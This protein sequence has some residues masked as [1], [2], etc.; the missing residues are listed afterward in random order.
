M[1]TAAEMAEA[2]A[3]AVTAVAMAMIPRALARATRYGATS[4]LLAGLPAP[5]VRCCLQQPAAPT[6]CSS[7]LGGAPRAP[8]E[9]KWLRPRC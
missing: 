3:A 2:T 1:A 5:T 8:T 9:C 6:C 7:R 4:R